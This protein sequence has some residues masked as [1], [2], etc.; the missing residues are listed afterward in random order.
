MR[1]RKR[2]AQN[3]RGGRWPNSCRLRRASWRKPLASNRPSRSRA[4]H[5][6]NAEASGAGAADKG[7]AMSTDSILA[8]ALAYAERGWMLFPAPPGSKKSHVSR[9]YDPN[10]RNWGMTNDPAQIKQYWEDFPAANVGLPT[11]TENGFWVCEADT[12]KGHGIDGIASLRA[13]EQQHATLPPT[14]MAE[15]PSGSLHYY[16]RQPDGIKI[17]NSTSMVAPGV[18]VKGEGG[19]VIAPPSV[20]HD[21]VYRWRN[22]LPIADP[23]AWLVQLV[24]AASRQRENRSNGGKPHAITDPWE[25]G[26]FAAA[27][28]ALKNNYDWQNWN[29]FIMAIYFATGGSE[30]GRKLTHE[31]SKNGVAT[32][33]RRRTTGGTRCMGARLRT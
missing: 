10:E 13:L 22:E 27:V 24:T 31:F 33:P 23:P 29:R 1:A 25:A 12:I 7:R 20:R 26:C 16:F 3:L 19:M 6:Q 2:H 32:T 5:F 14:L 11:G 4:R 8:A 18:D 9:K 30:E 17:T 21:G 15:S 28:A